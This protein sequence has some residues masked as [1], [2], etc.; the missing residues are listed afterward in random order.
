[1]PFNNLLDSARDKH[2]VCML[3]APRAKKEQF[4]TDPRSHEAE[5]RKDADDFFQPTQLFPPVTDPE[6]SD[7]LISSFCRCVAYSTVHL[8]TH[9]TT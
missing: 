3:G 9:V 5:M 1:M 7:S 6:H 2:W 8:R 4:C